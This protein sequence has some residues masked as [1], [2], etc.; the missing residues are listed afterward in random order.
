MKT[1]TEAELDQI[2]QRI[3]ATGSKSCPDC[4][5]PTLTLTLDA[6]FTRIRC[7]SC[8]FLHEDFFGG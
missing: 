2:T 4:Q 6:N 8:D 5:K 7:S 3:M 1:R